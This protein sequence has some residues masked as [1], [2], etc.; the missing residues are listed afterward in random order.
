MKQTYLKQDINK[1]G[2]DILPEYVDHQVL[3]IDNVCTRTSIMKEKA[4]PGLHNIFP[5]CL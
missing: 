3:L 4:I 5:L 1:R 2:V